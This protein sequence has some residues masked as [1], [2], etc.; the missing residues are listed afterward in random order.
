[1]Q[2]LESK[3]T[4]EVFR[5]ENLSQAKT[6]AQELA[7]NFLSTASHSPTSI[8]EA[9]KSFKDVVEEIPS[10]FERE[11]NYLTQGIEYFQNNKVSDL[12][13]LESQ[14]SELE[15][16]LETK[17]NSKLLAQKKFDEAMKVIQTEI[18][19]LTKEANAAKTQAQDT[20][21]EYDNL[22][23]ESSNP[24][25]IE[26]KRIEGKTAIDISQSTDRSLRGKKIEKYDIKHEG[27]R[28]IFRMED[29]IK[30]EEKQL[31]KHKKVL[32]EK[33]KELSRTLSEWISVLQ[34][35]IKFCE[36]GGDLH[37]IDIARIDTKARVEG[38]LA[39]LTELLEAYSKEFDRLD[40]FAGSDS[41]LRPVSPNPGRENQESFKYFRDNEE[42]SSP[43][44]FYTGQIL[45]TC[46]DSASREFVSCCIVEVF[47]P[48]SKRHVAFHLPPPWI[49]KFMQTT[50]SF[51]RYGAGFF[52]ENLKDFVESEN[53]SFEDLNITIVSGVAVPPDQIAVSLEL[54]GCKREKIKVAQVPA[55]NFFTLTLADQKRILI[56]GQEVKF[57]TEH[58]VAEEHHFRTMGKK[59]PYQ[60]TG[61]KVRF[62]V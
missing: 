1:M 2:D 6:H 28:E 39:E 61:E 30:E 29:E 40:S 15:K 37:D 26:A 34:E 24:D 55:D 16:S 38:V 41:K 27:E 44:L 10:M 11:K 18:E 45:D 31:E 3:K 14:I 7:N 53:C 52:Y 13:P 51:K 5:P 8:T 32:L 17:R 59:Q 43:A 36:S 62:V 4:S 56:Q 33:V 22:A 48:K 19:N 23:S 21:A 47:S 46:N 50:G 57:K 60:T 20:S 9:I 49:K 58:E 54:V 25:E 12:P 35:R 42:N